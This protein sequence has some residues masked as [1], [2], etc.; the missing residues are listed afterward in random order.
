MIRYSKTITSALAAAVCGGLVLGLANP[1]HAASATDKLELSTNVKTGSVPR[2]IE[3]DESKGRAYFVNSYTSDS[4]KKDTVTWLDTKT[5]TPSETAWELP[6]KDP[7]YFTLNS[8][9]S[10]LYAV[11]NKSGNVSIVDTITGT[12]ETVTT[13]TKYPSGITADTD[14]GAVYVYDSKGLQRIDPDTNKVSERIVVSDEKYPSIQDVVYD[15]PNKLLWIAE[16]REKVVTAYSTSA[17]IW[18]QKAKLPTAELKYNGDAL[19]GRPKLLA[20]DPQLNLLHILQRAT[21]SDNWKNDRVITYDT[22]AQSVRGDTYIEVGENAY[23]MTVNKATHEIYTTNGH[24]NSV[25]V[26]SPETWQAS[27]AA[28]FNTLK[29]TSG[30]GSGEANT[31]GIAFNGAGSTAYVTHPYKTASISVLTRTGE[32]PTVTQRKAKPAEGHEADEAAPTSWAGPAAQTPVA[33]D[34][35]AVTTGNAQLAW[36]I[37]DYTQAWRSTPLG[38]TSKQDHVFQ[39]TSG[40]GW[41]NE[42]T[43][44]A[45]IAWAD[46]LNIT[47]YPTLVPDLQSI[48]GNPVLTVNAN[49]TATLSYDIKWILSKTESSDGYKRLTVATFK[50]VNLVK[51]GDT[52]AMTATPEYDGRAYTAASGKVHS[53]SYPAEFIDYH[54]PQMRPWWYSTGANLDSAKVPLPVTVSFTATQ[55]I[56]D[57]ATAAPDA[58]AAS[59]AR[60]S[61]VL[62]ATGSTPSVS[63]PNDSS[64]AAEQK[65]GT[66][67]TL[68]NTGNTAGTLPAIAA[69]TALLTGVCTITVA[70]TRAKRERAS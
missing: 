38:K 46:G 17:Q 8:D 67:K 24:S 51:T 14:T 69:L 62:P 40:S 15:A 12:V 5:N 20:I 63:V 13:E 39:W 16:G 9:G 65:A 31:W 3:V 35:C 33:T 11:H 32:K 1:T 22:K 27:E 7:G 70:R 64:T 36:G 61:A 34:A 50:D 52:V 4:S 10:K 60:S 42:K 21:T 23:K 30:T 57:A 2:D 48:W 41:Y 47:H 58:P 45:Q 49:K 55:S 56:C 29:I 66:Q 37:S 54:N 44:E 25:S 19:S 18:M 6:T 26:I 28:N 43:G 53:S 59:D 68:A